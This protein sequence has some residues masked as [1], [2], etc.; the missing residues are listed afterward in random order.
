MLLFLF[1]CDKRLFNSCF[2]NNSEGR[3]LIEELDFGDT[4]GERGLGGVNRVGSILV[5]LT[6]HAKLFQ[7]IPCEIILIE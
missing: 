2:L 3:L 4:A 6:E 7:W 5:L 1:H